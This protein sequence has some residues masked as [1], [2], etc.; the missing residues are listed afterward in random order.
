MN[1]LLPVPCL[2]CQIHISKHWIRNIS[3]IDWLG[4]FQGYIFVCV[5]RRAQRELFE[6]GGVFWGFCLNFF[7][8]KRQVRPAHIAKNLNKCAGGERWIKTLPPMMLN[9]TLKTVFYAFFTLHLYKY[10]KKFK[11]SGFANDHTVMCW[12]GNIYHLGYINYKYM[13]FKN[14]LKSRVYL[15]STSV[16]LWPSDNDCSTIHSRALFE[17]NWNVIGLTHVLNGRR[18]RIWDGLENSSNR[19]FK[20]EYQWKQLLQQ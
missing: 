5:L 1:R 9:P 11:P 20:H 8:I 19:Q 14:L 2:G 3:F 16:V 7:W 15:H 13:P 17:G 12:W 4:N 10:R 6:M 18:I